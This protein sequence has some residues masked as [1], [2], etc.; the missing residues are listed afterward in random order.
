MFASNF[1]IADTHLKHVR[2]QE[3][4][5]QFSQ[6]KTIWSG[7]KMTNYNCSECSILMYRIGEGFP[8]MSI[9]RI[10]TVDDFQLHETKLKPRVEQ[11]CKDRVAWFSGVEGVPQVEASAYSEEGQKERK[12]KQ[13]KL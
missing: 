8:G 7:K 2:G 1:C 10:G 5:K 3:K 9:L 13:E 4:L 12:A 6:S 11:F